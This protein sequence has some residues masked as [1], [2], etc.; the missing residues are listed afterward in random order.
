MLALRRAAYIRPQVRCLAAINPPTKRWGP[1]APPTTT[2]LPRGCLVGAVVST[3]FVS[4]RGL[5]NPYTLSGTIVVDGVAASCHSSWILDGLLPPRVAVRVTWSRV[6]A[7]AATW[8][9]LGRYVP[10]G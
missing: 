4:K 1:P 2:N 7:A 9:V 8:V 5:Y 6:D 3:A 10:Y